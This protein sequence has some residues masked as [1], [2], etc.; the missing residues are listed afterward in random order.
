MI[1]KFIRRWAV[2]QFRLIKMQCINKQIKNI[3]APFTEGF[4]FDWIRLINIWQNESPARGYQ[5]LYIN[6][7][8]EYRSADSYGAT[9]YHQRAATREVRQRAITNGIVH[10]KVISS[11]GVLYTV[12]QKPWLSSRTLFVWVWMRSINLISI[13]L[14]TKLSLQEPHLVAWS[15]VSEHGSNDWWFKSQKI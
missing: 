5:F 1:I 8:H 15:V 4:S 12:V 3:E 6:L 9:H 7:R 13:T 10:I 11:C 14:L 2:L